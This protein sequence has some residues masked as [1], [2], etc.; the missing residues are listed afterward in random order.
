M[1]VP[2]MNDLTVRS[3]FSAALHAWQ[4]SWDSTSLGWFKTCPRLYQYQMLMQL[5][6]RSKGI[7]LFF[8][9]LYASALER[10]AHVRAIGTSHDAATVSVVRWLLEETWL[11]MDTLTGAP[12]PW[13][14]NDP[15][16][17]RY[18][19]VRSFVWNVEERLTSPFTT[20]ILANGKPAVELSFQ[21]AA[22]EVAGEPITLCGH[23]DEIVD[24]NGGSVWVRDD[25]TTKS[26][27]NAQYFSHY[28]PNNQMSLYSIAGKIILD[29]PVRGVLVKAAQIGVGFT[30][31]VTQQVPRTEAVLTEW[32]AD[33]RHWIELAH[34]Y[35]LA[36]YW[37][38]NDSS[39]DKFG[40]CPFRKVCSVSPS[41]RPAWLEQDFITHEWNPLKARGL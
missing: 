30:R 28:T 35:A 3:P 17:N 6:P 32:L 8:G 23:L 19:L 7:H 9:G 13:E 1:N 16:K 33:T 12:G 27:L 40:G 26:A 25:K 39:C 22:F 11:P 24:D 10:Y 5:S 38:M 34:E 14:S 2:T 4:T 15:Y 36:S 20:H 18:T 31:F 37:P 21:F 41:H 29:A